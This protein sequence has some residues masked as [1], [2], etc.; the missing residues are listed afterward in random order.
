MRHKPN[1]VSLIQEYENGNMK[2]REFCSKHKIKYS[3]FQFWLAR[4]RKQSRNGAQ[5]LPVRVVDRDITGHIPVQAEI[6]YP[7]GTVLKIANI[8]AEV[9]RQLLPAFQL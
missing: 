6:F 8:S 2:Q 3:A 1:Y 5:F 4:V 9:V 7:D